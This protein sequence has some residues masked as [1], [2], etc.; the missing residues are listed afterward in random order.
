MLFDWIEFLKLAKKLQDE[1]NISGSSE[2]AYRS[3][4]S[5]AYYAAFQASLE[6][7]KSIGYIPKNTGDDH[8]SIQRFFSNSTTKDSLKKKISTQL[9]R[10]YEYRQKADYFN[11][12]VN[13]KP[14]NL[15]FYAV[16]SSVTI[17]DCISELK[18]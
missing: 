8:K 2:A 11:P 15:A 7:G 5:R 3:A 16:Q 1:P 12:I 13:P 6:Y 10:L 14:E 4:A 17:F 9:N 18:K